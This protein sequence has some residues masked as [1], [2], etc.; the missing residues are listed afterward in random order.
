MGSPRELTTDEYVMLKAEEGLHLLEA[1]TWLDVSDGAV[2]V[3]TA[4]SVSLL[5]LS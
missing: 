5:A 1:P 4:Q 2:H 3:S